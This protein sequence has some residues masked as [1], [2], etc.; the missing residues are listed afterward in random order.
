MGFSSFDP[1]PALLLG[2][3]QAGHASGAGTTRYFLGRD[4]SFSFNYFI[5]GVI[6]GSQ[7]RC[8]IDAQGRAARKAGCMAPSHLLD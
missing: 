6:Q 1:I 5:G 4:V 2:T 3:S 8:F 7:P